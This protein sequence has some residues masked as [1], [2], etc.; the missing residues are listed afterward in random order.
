[1][2]EI[3]IPEGSRDVAIDAGKHMGLLIAI[4]VVMLLI[5][6]WVYNAKWGIAGLWEQPIFI[7][8]TVAIMIVLHELIHGMSWMLA[9]GLRWQ[10]LKFGVQIKTLTPYCH[11][12]VP[13]TAQAYRI[14]VV[15]PGI[16]VGIVPML[17]AYLLGNAPLALI[18]AVMIS[19]AAG[20]AYV[21]W[22]VRDVPPT[23]YVMDHPSK[24]GC[25]VLPDNYRPQ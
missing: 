24:V 10:D 16:A 11:S 4:S 6:L 17:I 18:G 3:E 8:V 12:R 25:I 5:P 14:G 19:G 2:S 7:L 13:M 1:M 15:A 23:S 20:D 9:G 21:L 22:V